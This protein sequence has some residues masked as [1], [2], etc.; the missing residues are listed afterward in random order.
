MDHILVQVSECTNFQSVAVDYIFSQHL[1]FVSFGL[2]SK[3]KSATNGCSC[4]S[5]QATGGDRLTVIIVIYIVRG[6]NI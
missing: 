4:L 3:T 6:R 2:L 1:V 5:N